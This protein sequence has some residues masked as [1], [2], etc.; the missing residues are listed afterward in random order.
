M[1]GRLARSGWFA[2][3]W[4][5]VAVGTVGIVVPGLPTT[6]FFVVAA[7]C[8]SRSSPRFEQW[9]LDRPGVGPLVRD[10]R[11]GL[12]MPRGAKTAAVTSIAVV[13][14]LSAFVLLGHWGVRAT[15]LAAGARRDRLGPLAGPHPRRARR[16][17]ARSAGTL[18]RRRRD[19]RSAHVGRAARRPWP[20]ST[21]A[22][23]P[24]AAC[25]SAGRSTAWW[26]SGTSRSPCSRPSTWRGAGAP[27]RSRCSPR[28]HRSG[29]SCSSRGPVARAGWR[30]ARGSRRARH[31]ADQASSFAFWASN[32]AAEMTLRSRRSASLASSSAVL[33][34][35]AAVV[36]T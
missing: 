12:G 24:S 10:Y 35:L 36:R 25:R 23:G 31:R 14:S 5:S 4:A 9:V 32:S 8:F 1:S 20:S 30:R 34:P 29:R 22:A 19:G 7:A 3:G 2:L 26:C 6:V 27:S 33:P 18:V 21:S 17:G 15:V 16:A 28:C 11:A 13:C